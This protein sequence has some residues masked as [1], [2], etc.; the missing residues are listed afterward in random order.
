MPCSTAS[1]AS[2]RLFGFEMEKTFSGQTFDGIYENGGFFSETYFEDG[3]IRSIKINGT[4]I[5][6]AE[7]QSVYDGRKIHFRISDLLPGSN[8]IEVAYT[9]HFSKD[10]IG[11]NRFKD[12]EDGQVY[13]HSNLEPFGAHRVFPCFDQPDIKGSFE[14]TVEAPENWQVI[15]NM[16]ERG[17]RG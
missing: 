6:Q 5:P 10:G 14:V 9:H 16:P 12:P 15:A 3:S 8:L 1:R 2:E 17:S 7:I 4:T 13:L 11:L